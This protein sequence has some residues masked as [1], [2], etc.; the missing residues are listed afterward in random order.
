[1]KKHPRK[2]L[3]DQITIKSAAKWANESHDLAVKYAYTLKPGDHPTDEYRAQA[4]KTSEERLV[5]AGYRLGD[6][7]NRLL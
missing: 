1:M 3:S 7:L 4:Q 5:L 2:S 6:G